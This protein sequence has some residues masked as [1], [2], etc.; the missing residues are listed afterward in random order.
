M[1]SPRNQK[2][3][4]LEALRGLAA[5]VV[6]AWHLVLAFAPGRSGIFPSMDFSSSWIGMPWYSLINGSAAVIFFFVL[7]GFVLTRQALRT[8]T[9]RRLAVGAVKRWPRLAGPVTVSCVLS[10][11]LFATDLYRFRQ[12]AAVTGS[13]WLADF[14]YSG[15]HPSYIP[16]LA[17]AVLQGSF[18]TFL[19]G[20]A[21]FN[22]SLWTMR[23]EL[24]GSFIAF[25]M[26]LLLLELRQTRLQL[27]LL[28]VTLLV[29]A[30]INVLLV[31]FPAGVS[32][33]F[34]S[35]RARLPQ[36]GNLSASVLVVLAFTCA[37][38]SET[39]LLGRL[40]AGWLS[41]PVS[42]PL[43]YTIGSL[44]L[45]LA[46]ERNHLF[47]FLL[48]GRAARALGTMSFPIY[49]VHIPALCSAGCAA[50][51]AFQ[52]GRTGFIA[53]VAS[54]LCLTLLLSWPLSRF[55]AWWTKLVNRVVNRP[56]APS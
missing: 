1:E 19:T 15:M 48:S 42:A 43:V 52:G 32:L 55:D 39:S 47:R 14:A 18:W 53:A 40:S 26:G 36:I 11:C 38:Y 6:V 51:L 45:L 12:A 7:S 2:D 3:E 22:S 46:A 41:Y 13:P 35:T 10:W 16:R 31:A 37:T 56:T 29:T 44:F 49:L 33:A 50:F 28:A 24:W 27:A 23:W 8:G 21:S 20:I 25:S 17:D 54:T 5:L 34:L 9:S 4:P 30:Y